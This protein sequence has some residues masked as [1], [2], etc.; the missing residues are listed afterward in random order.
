MAM[1]PS[2]LSQ[3]VLG[4]GVGLLVVGQDMPVQ[5]RA[6]MLRMSGMAQP[7]QGFSMQLTRPLTRDPRPL[8]SHH[9][10]RLGPPPDRSEP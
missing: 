8:L 4:L 7:D 3:P 6:Q 9:R 1:T 5:Q 10:S 2:P